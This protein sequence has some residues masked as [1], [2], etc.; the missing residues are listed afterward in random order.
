MKLRLPDEIKVFD[1]IKVIVEWTEGMQAADFALEYDS[2][3]LEFVE[4]DIEENFT[5]IK[6]NHILYR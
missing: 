5:N 4:A 6:D 1:K 3:K 2:E